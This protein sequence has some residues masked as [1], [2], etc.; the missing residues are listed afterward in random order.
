MSAH[1]FLVLGYNMPDFEL[2]D[3]ALIPTTEIYQIEELDIREPG[4]KEFLVQL[5]QTVNTIA[6]IMNM[7]DTGYYMTNEIANSQ[8][9]FNASGNTLQTGTEP[10]PVY[11]KVVWWNQ[12]LPN[13]AIATMPHNIQGI[14]INTP[15]PANP[16]TN[17]RFTKIYGC[18]TDPGNSAAPRNPEFIPLPYS[19]TIDPIN[20]IELSANQTNVTIRTGIDRTRFTS[21][22]IVLE[23]V[24][25]S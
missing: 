5:T 22:F 8:Y 23:Y 13:A 16:W 15:P 17:F 6:L 4:L 19:S 7:K 14:L 10:R 2:P 11:R 24:K 21:A 3:S 1:T 18:A 20:N 9:F 12:P 25:E